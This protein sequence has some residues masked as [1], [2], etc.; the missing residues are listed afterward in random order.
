LFFEGRFAFPASGLFYS[1]LRKIADFV[2][3]SPLFLCFC[4]FVSVP[5]FLFLCFC[6]CSFVSVPLFLFLFLC[7]CSCLLFCSRY[8]CS[9][10]LFPFS[11]RFLSSPSAFLV[12]NFVF[13]QAFSFFCRSLFPYS[14]LFFLYSN[15][16][17]QVFFVNGV[18]YCY[19]FIVH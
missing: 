5:L 1:F 10:F 14:S 16:N 17:T 2:Y 4:S 3:V 18:Y 11:F 13:C 19:S 9:F 12:L 8:P 6:F 15:F 7:L